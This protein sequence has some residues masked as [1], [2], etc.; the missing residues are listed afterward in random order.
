MPNLSE[1]EHVT[2]EQVVELARQIEGGEEGEQAPD[3]QRLARLVLQFHAAVV[4]G[5]AKPSSK[6]P[7]PSRS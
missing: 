7:P 6:V 4:G 1:P 5:K 2:W 3:S